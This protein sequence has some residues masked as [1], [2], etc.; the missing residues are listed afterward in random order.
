[1]TEYIV[2][3]TRGIEYVSADSCH[4]FPPSDISAPMAQF[5]RKREGGKDS[6]QCHTSRNVISVWYNTEI[7]AQEDGKTGRRNDITPC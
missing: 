1:M 4:L 3:T 2:N 6:C 7:A 5:Y